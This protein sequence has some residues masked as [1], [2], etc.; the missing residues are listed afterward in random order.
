METSVTGVTS[1]PSVSKSTGCAGGLY[2]MA[3]KNSRPITPLGVKVISK[4]KTI[5]DNA[6]H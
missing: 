4:S 3:K 5:M 1:A 6:L 2:G